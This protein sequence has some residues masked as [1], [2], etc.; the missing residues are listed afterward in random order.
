MQLSCIHSVIKWWVLK[1]LVDLFCRTC[2]T[3]LSALDRLLHRSRKNSLHANWPSYPLWFLCSNISSIFAAASAGCYSEILSLVVQ[4][5]LP[6]SLPQAHIHRCS[7]LSLLWNSSLSIQ[8]SSVPAA[9]PVRYNSGYAVCVIFLFSS[10]LQLACALN[11]TSHLCREHGSSCL[12]FCEARLQ[13]MRITTQLLN[14]AT[15]R[16]ELASDVW[17]M[18]WWMHNSTDSTW[19]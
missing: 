17:M 11:L 1:I 19:A 4:F 12:C 2:A 15:A 10:G 6:L 9:P 3:S 18:G 14:E 7:I 13:E 16:R 5:P 8:F